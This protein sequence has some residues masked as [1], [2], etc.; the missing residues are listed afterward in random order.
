MHRWC[1][2]VDSE[3]LVEAVTLLKGDI[4]PLLAEIPPNDAHILEADVTRTFDAFEREYPGCDSEVN[5]TELRQILAIA[6]HEAGCG[7]CQGLNFVTGVVLLGARQEIRPL[8]RRLG[9]KRDQL[10]RLV[11][12]YGPALALCVVRRLLKRHGFAALYHRE[13]RLSP[14]DSPPSALSLP[15]DTSFGSSAATTTSP[16]ITS[17]APATTPT[18]AV[19]SR[20]DVDPDADSPI[21]AATATPEESAPAP[22]QL[23]DPAADHDANPPIA[24]S[25]PSPTEPTVMEVRSI[26]MPSPLQLMTHIFI[27]LLELHAP[28]VYEHLDGSQFSPEILAVRW[29][30][31]CFATSLPVNGVLMT[32]DAVLAGIPNVMLRLGAGIL[33][34]LED[35]VLRMCQDDLMIR[36]SGAVREVDLADAW[37]RAL[38]LPAS[39]IAGDRY[40]RP[41]R[42]EASLYIHHQQS[43]H[44]AATAAAAAKARA[45]SA[46]A[47]PSDLSDLALGAGVVSVVEEGFDDDDDGS[48]S[49]APSA[50]GS[51]RELLA[52]PVPKVRS[53]RF[54]VDPSTT[55]EAAVTTWF[56]DAD[57]DDNDDDDE[58]EAVSTAVHVDSDNGDGR[59]TAMAAATKPTAHIASAR[60]RLR[61]SLT[62]ALAATRMMRSV[63]SSDVVAPIVARLRSGLLGEMLRS[64]AASSAGPAGPTP[65]VALASAAQFPAEGLVMDALMAM[66]AGTMPP[67]TELRLFGESEEKARRST[68]E[69]AA[70]TMPDLDLLPVLLSGAGPPPAAAGAGRAGHRL[71]RERSDSD[72][73]SVSA[74][75][76]ADEATTAAPSEPETGAGDTASPIRGR[77]RRARRARAI[78][79]GVSGWALDAVNLREWGVV[80]VASG[81]WRRWAVASLCCIE[82]KAGVAWYYIRVRVPEA[83]VDFVSCH[84]FSQFDA[85]MTA[86]RSSEVVAELGRAAEAMHVPW[87]APIG[88]VMDAPSS[89]STHIAHDDIPIADPGAPALPS[90][91]ARSSGSDSAA[92][93]PHRFVVTDSEGIEWGS[94]RYYEAPSSTAPTREADAKPAA[95]DEGDVDSVAIIQRDAL[96]LQA[97]P[98]V[99][100]RSFSQGD[101]SAA[102][103]AGL[104]S[105]R[106]ALASPSSLAEAA[107]GAGTA[108]GGS[109]LPSADSMMTTPPTSPPVSALASPS[110]LDSV[111]FE[112]QGGDVTAAAASSSATAAAALISPRQASPLRAS[113]TASSPALSAIS[114]GG[115]SS[116][117]TLLAPRLPSMPPKTW[118]ML[119]PMRPPFLR[120][121]GR[122][123]CQ[124]VQQLLDTPFLAR[125]P[126]VSE[127]L[128]IDWE[129]MR[130][131]IALPLARRQALYQWPSWSWEEQFSDMS[132]AVTRLKLDRTLP[133]D[134]VA[135]GIRLLQARIDELSQHPSRASPP[136]LPSIVRRA[137]Q[138][139]PPATPGAADSATAA[140]SGGTPV[141]PPAGEA[142]I[143]E[144]EP[145]PLA[146]DRQRRRGGSDGSGSGSAASSSGRSDDGREPPGEDAEAEAPSSSTGRRITLDGAHR[147]R[148][149]HSRIPVHVLSARA[150]V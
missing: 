124:M 103:S 87:P 32:I 118:F 93:D 7:Y 101:P 42:S 133:I 67:L 44:H 16:T 142:P 37:T 55:T 109:D 147:L 22:L 56:D 108:T 134:V 28:R 132:G 139:T 24:A 141:V 19:A 23:G 138:V 3:E 9:A 77:S 146:S 83:L 54:D 131:R 136:R 73:P 15:N 112:L 66:Q 41:A 47:D 149:T 135:A 119:G 50:S 43:A 116:S 38:A 39:L 70:D 96:T 8:L 72:L 33:L 27:R 137:Q 75:A 106:S 97:S 21:L 69:S 123:L 11:A 107:I 78:A 14:P 127:F 114:A 115:S 99:M 144:L 98:G 40:G 59:G 86:L 102:T 5:R 143:A 128:G 91:V 46:A 117:S 81:A 6:V 13:I 125:H 130:A 34:S 52:Q 63:F 4:V 65:E 111:R 60:Q 61:A 31:T 85:L 35:Q 110:S 89:D 140:S 94:P 74:A 64:G 92:S 122:D 88:G 76:G 12:Q 95:V 49:G 126:L 29:F 10:P 48:T 26:P 51:R 145:S 113:L 100:Q 121:R 25:A 148:P 57:D 18:A 36:L 2:I 62:A 79:A 30:A 82:T 104:F 120:R 53:V 84:R 129:A 150:L 71:S 105:P 17:T 45:A 58:K 90:T 1:N 20:V 80:P 68:S